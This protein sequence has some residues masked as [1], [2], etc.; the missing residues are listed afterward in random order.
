MVVVGLQLQTMKQNYSRKYQNM[1]NM[2][3]GMS[4]IPDEIISKVRSKIKTV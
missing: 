3:H 2:I 1:Q 4:E